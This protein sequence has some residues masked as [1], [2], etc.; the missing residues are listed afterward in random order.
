M[1]AVRISEM[2]IMS[3]DTKAD[4]TRTREQLRKECHAL[5]QRREA[6]AARW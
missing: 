2:D 4:I 6:M 3:T 5:L 1:K